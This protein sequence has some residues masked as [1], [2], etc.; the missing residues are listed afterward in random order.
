MKFSSL[1]LLASFTKFSTLVVAEEDGQL[2]GLWGN[3][4]DGDYG[5]DRWWGGGDKRWGGNV[6]E[7]AEGAV[8]YECSGWLWWKSCTPYTCQDFSEDTCSDYILVKHACP[9]T[10]G[11]GRCKTIVDIAM[12]SNRLSSLV[13]AVVAA[14]LVEVL[15]TNGGGEGLTVLAPTD[16]AFSYVPEPLLNKLLNDD[17]WKGHLNSLLLYHV[18][19][20][21]IFSTD[22]KA[23]LKVRTLNGEEVEAV[24]TSDSVGFIDS[25]EQ[26]ANV[27]IDDG[28]VDIKAANGVVHV[29][30]K[31]L[32]PSWI[33]SSVVDLAVAAAQNEVQKELT[34][35]VSLLDAFQLVEPLNGE[36]PFT[37]FAPTDKA[38]SDIS[39]VL[40]GA[41]DETVLDVLKY[42]VVPGIYLSSDLENGE[43]LETLN[44]EKIVV[45]ADLFDIKLNNNVT[46][47][48]PDN[49][50]NNG[51]VHI[52]S[53]VLIPPSIDGGVSCADKT[54]PFTPVDGGTGGGRNTAAMIFPRKAFG[55]VGTAAFLALIALNH[56]DGAAFKTRFQHTKQGKHS[57]GKDMPSGNF[58]KYICVMES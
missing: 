23:G 38:F 27:A 45:T 19:P 26:T 46:I 58:T 50:A 32:I 7:D 54:G 49:L 40:D 42:H 55:V 48:A 44:G 22:I 6:C 10:C 34:T 33:L 13:K 35:L 20:G 37:V 36:G 8:H 5:M 24:V 11:S 9:V 2:R 15:K 53:S 21:Q 3:D 18:V 52:V 12:D 16:K 41:S 31:V 28:L 1:L 29:I 39:D 57:G 4:K 43:E 30:N 56:V 14:D 25:A 47:A 17:S 51:V